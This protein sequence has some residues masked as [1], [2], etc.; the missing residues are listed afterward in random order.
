MRPPWYFVLPEEGERELP[1]G[2]NIYNDRIIQAL[3]QVSQPVNIVPVDGYLQAVRQDKGGIYWVDT[4]LLES[5]QEILALRPSRAHSLL[6]VHHLESLAPP[7]GQSAEVLLAKEKPFLDWFQGFLASS[8]FTRDYLQQQGVSQPIIV[9]EPGV[10]IIPN[11]KAFHYRTTD[12]LRALMVA[13]LVERKGILSFLQHLAPAL[14]A[15]DQFSI[16]VV[17]RTDIEPGYAQR[18]LDL[19]QHHSWLKQRVTLAGNQP[20]KQMPSFYRQANLFISTASMETFGIALQEARLHRLPILTL[21]A[22]YSARHVTT[23]Q[24]GYVLANLPDIVD[25]FLNL[26]REPTKFT[27][28]Y[29]QAQQ[30]PSDYLRWD[31]SARQL[32][33][34]FDQ[35]FYYAP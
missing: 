34:Q 8:T 1:S 21:S 26:V 12:S 15:T 6:I 27:T 10:D 14:Q 24:N 2:G 18:C 3:T 20:P 7:A 4:L 25:F 35:F 28:L 30:Q 11:Q 31:Q 33:Q 23:G 19:V 13:N 32:V 9:A 5:L 29:Q 17:G 16:T 22:G